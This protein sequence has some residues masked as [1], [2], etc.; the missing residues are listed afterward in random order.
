M[1]S[2][3]VNAKFFSYSR[4]LQDLNWK[5]VDSDS[6]SSPVV[7]DSESDLVDSTTS[8]E[9]RTN[10][11][12]V[13]LCGYALISINLQSLNLTLILECLVGPGLVLEPRVLVRPNITDLKQLSRTF[14]A[15]WQYRD[16]T[17]WIWIYVDCMAELTDTAIWIWELRSVNAL[18]MIHSYNVTVS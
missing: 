13:R 5:S 6:D 16:E 11:L 2:Y 8:L 4:I 14:E 18:M 3:S 17:A 9:W 10:I 12:I 7:L 15:I 1:L